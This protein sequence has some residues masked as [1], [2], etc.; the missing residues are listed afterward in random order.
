M[1]NVKDAALT[2]HRCY[3]TVYYWFN[4]NEWVGMEE[5]FTCFKAFPV[6]KVWNLSKVLQWP[7]WSLCSR[8]QFWPPGLMFDACDINALWGFIHW[9]VWSLFRFINQLW[10]TNFFNSPR[11][12]ELFLR[13]NDWSEWFLTLNLLTYYL[14]NSFFFSA[15]AVSD[16]LPGLSFV[17]LS[18]PWTKFKYLFW[19]NWKGSWP[20]VIQASKD[21]LKKSRGSSVAVQC[22]A[23]TWVCAHR[24][25]AHPQQGRDQY[26]ILKSASWFGIKDI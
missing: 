18:F 12:S 17:R 24:F 14:L 2:A 3:W 23:S 25:S 15:T 20:V 13:W 16:L 11:T 7:D 5:L 9:A 6:D 19:D 4:K 1:C 21:P 8:D 10:A 26:I 22:A